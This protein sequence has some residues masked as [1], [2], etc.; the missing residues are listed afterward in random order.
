VVIG[1]EKNWLYHRY[2]MLPPKDLRIVAMVNIYQRVVPICST[3]AAA[4]IPYRA[5]LYLAIESSTP[6]KRWFFPFKVVSI[7]EKSRDSKSTGT[8]FL[9]PKI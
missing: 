5:H 8:C 6:E 2:F 3:A 1:A 9:K 4:P 7:E